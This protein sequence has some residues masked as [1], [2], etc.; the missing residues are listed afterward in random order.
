MY[1]TIEIEKPAPGTAVAAISGQCDVYGAPDVR[2]ALIGLINEGVYRQVIDLSGVELLDSS[3][4]AVLV[5]AWGRARAHGGEVVFAVDLDS[6]A[7]KVLRITGVH[8]SIRNAATVDEALGLLAQP[9]P[10]TPS[11][12]PPQV[13]DVW[14]GQLD[15][16]SPKT[17]VCEKPG[18]LSGVH[19]WTAEGT[20][21]KFGPLKLVWRDGAVVAAGHSSELAA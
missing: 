19:D 18:V 12:W 15:K 11:F 17:W 14:L 16:P 9:Q 4:L 3:G 21:R 13:G 5:G 2:N 6:R 7:G 8:K 1:A 10:E 20:Y